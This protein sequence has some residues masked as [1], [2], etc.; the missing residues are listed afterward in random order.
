MAKASTDSS[1]PVKE[2]H[3]LYAENMAFAGYGIPLWDPEPLKGE[4]EVVLGDVGILRNGHFR[5]LFN[6]LASGGHFWNAKGVPQDFVQHRLGTARID[7]PHD[8]EATLLHSPSIRVESL[9]SEAARL[10]V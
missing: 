2:P 3:V 6:V 5:R 10:C 4:D 9:Q 8:V 7:G 1:T